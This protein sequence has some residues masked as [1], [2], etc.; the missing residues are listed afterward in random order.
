MS[1]DAGIKEAIERI[2]QELQRDPES[3]QG[4]THTTARLENGLT[5]V[6]AEDGWTLTSDVPPSVG[7]DGRDRHREFTGELR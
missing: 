6:V 5:C 3:A 1:T 2:V 7:G 4:T